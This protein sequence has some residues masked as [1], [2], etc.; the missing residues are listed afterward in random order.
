MINL[1]FIGIERIIPFNGPK[2]TGNVATHETGISA[3]QLLFC[4][5]I[6]NG[7]ALNDKGYNF[8]EAEEQ[9]AFVIEALYPVSKASEIGNDSSQIQLSNQCQRVRQFTEQTRRKPS[10]QHVK[11]MNSPF[12]EED[13]PGKNLLV[14]MQEG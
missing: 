7:L 14:Q 4:N 5:E 10:Q 6:Q 2:T 3:T 11:R 9:N 13:F 1:F 12:R 8:P